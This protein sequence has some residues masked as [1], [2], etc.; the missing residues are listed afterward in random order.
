MS[1]NQD[2]LFMVTKSIIN[3]LKTRDI[4]K[5]DELLS[6]SVQVHQIDNKWYSKYEWIDQIQNKEVQYLKL[7][8]M[9]NYVTNGNQGVIRLSANVMNKKLVMTKTELIFLL[10]KDIDNWQIINSSVNPI[11]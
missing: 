10:K 3:T 6:D 11:N 8:P 7:I 1:V 4:C 2:D 9:S 5:L